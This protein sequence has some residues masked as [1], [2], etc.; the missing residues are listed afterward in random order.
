MTMIDAR[1]PVVRGQRLSVAAE[2]INFLNRAMRGT[3]GFAGGVLDVGSH[4]PHVWVYAK[5]STGADVARWAAMEITGVD[6]T[7]TSDDQDGETQQFF[8]APV[9]TAGDIEGSTD[10]WCVALEPI[11]SDAIGRVAISGAVQ[12][13]ESDL[14]KCDGAIV[15]WKNDDWALIGRSLAAVRLGTISTTWSKGSTAT[16]T[17]INGDGTAIP[18][19]PT[20]EAK[21]WFSTVTVP[22]SPK[23]VACAKVTDTWILIA[24]EC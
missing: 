20:F 8:L 7:P 14:S 17:Q 2:Q 5:N 18:Q 9:L 24:A 23:K 6:V 13:R 11:K 19:S 15:Y 1:L 4:S 16:V 12:L 10:N 3:A 21:N 22:S